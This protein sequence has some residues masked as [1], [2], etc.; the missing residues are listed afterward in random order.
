MICIFEQDFE[1]MLQQYENSIDDKRQFTALVKD[2]FPQD[3]KNINLIL[4]AYNLGI[5]QDIQ[6]VKLLKI[7]GVTNP[8]Y[9]IRAS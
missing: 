1:A 3:A 8:R 7:L 5:A 4:M 6:K 9:G 2:I